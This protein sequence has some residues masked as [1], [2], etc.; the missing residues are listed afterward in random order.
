MSSKGD[1]ICTDG[2]AGTIRTSPIAADP[3][4][5]VKQEMVEQRRLE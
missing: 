1:R 4:Q 3:Q 5:T 2:I